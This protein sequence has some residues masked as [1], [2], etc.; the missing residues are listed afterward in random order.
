VK[1]NIF[2]KNREISVL[3]M[4][5]KQCVKANLKTSSTT[6]P[7]RQLTKPQLQLFRLNASIFCQNLNPI[8]PSH[9]AT[10]SSKWLHS[11]TTTG[12]VG[13]GGFSWQA[14]LAELC[15]QSYDFTCLP[16]WLWGA[17]RIVS[18]PNLVISSL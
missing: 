6:N 16:K 1:A 5:K 2:H 13:E 14:R 4:K 7:P 17:G 12:F 11:I 15:L 3:T 9:P 18:L 10:S 8:N